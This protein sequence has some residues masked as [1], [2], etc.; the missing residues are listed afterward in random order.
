MLWERKILGIYLV[1]GMRWVAS[2]TKP[3]CFQDFSFKPS[4]IRKDSQHINFHYKIPINLLLEI[5]KYGKKITHG[6][7]LSPVK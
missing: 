1:V 2:T 5:S 7:I 3:I 6:I 4:R